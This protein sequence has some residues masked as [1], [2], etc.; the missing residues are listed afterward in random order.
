MPR[1]R[2]RAH[3]EQL[4]EFEIGRFIE[5]KEEGWANLRIARHLGQSDAAII[6]CWQEWVDKGS[7]QCH[8]GSDRSRVTKDRK[9][10]LT[11]RSAITEPD[12]SISTT[13]RVTRTLV[14]FISIHRL[15]IE[16]NLRLNRPVRHLTLTTTHFRVRLQWC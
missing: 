4:S 7:F 15:L 5:L 16:Q 10:I 6:R 3:Y 2:I 8:D 14:S 9:G 12:S 11:V 1:R 13:R